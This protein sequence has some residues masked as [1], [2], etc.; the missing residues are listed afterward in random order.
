LVTVKLDGSRELFQGG[1]GR[2]SVADMGLEKRRIL[3]E[4][5]QVQNPRKT[6]V[7][8]PIGVVGGNRAKV[9]EKRRERSCLPGGADGG[10]FIAKGAVIG[11]RW[12]HGRLFRGG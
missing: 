6:R 7:D 10:V 8:V 5:E 9:G 2:S 3:K 12:N 1:V 4:K 11:C